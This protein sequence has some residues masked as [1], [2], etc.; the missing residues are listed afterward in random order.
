MTDR[1]LL[2]AAA[3]AVNGGA[4]HTLTHD[5]PSGVWNPLQDDGDAFRLA[6]RLGIGIA[7]PGNAFPN[8]RRAFL[9]DMRT[10][11]VTDLDAC[12]ATRRAIVRAAA[13]MGGSDD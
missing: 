8:V 6:V 9:S 3:K 7:R 11:S 2:D 13:A 10:F 4:W 12:A 1:E 5:T